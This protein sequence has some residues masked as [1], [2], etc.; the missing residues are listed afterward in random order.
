ML[1]HFGQ[2]FPL[3]NLIL[4]QLVQIHLGL[5]NPIVPRVETALHY[6]VEIALKTFELHNKKT[7]FFHCDD[8]LFHGVGCP[9]EIYAYPCVFL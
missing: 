9:V 2:Y 6:I 5:L 8:I 3:F 7:S 1:F 4:N